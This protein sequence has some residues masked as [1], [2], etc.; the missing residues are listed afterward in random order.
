MASLIWQNIGFTLPCQTPLKN[1][2]WTSWYV[3]SLAT[4]LFIQ[5]LV[6]ANDYEIIQVSYYWPF[7]RGIH[8][9]Q[10]DSPHKGPA[11]WK[12]VLYHDIITN[13]GP[14]SSQKRSLPGLTLFTYNIHT[15]LSFQTF[16]L[17][18]IESSP[19]PPTGSPSSQ[20]WEHSTSWRI[21]IIIRGTSPSPRYTWSLTP[22]YGNVNL[23]WERT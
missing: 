1:I 4:P 21:R 19:A 11:M 22:H 10:V 16:S 20:R 7:V 12:M 9:S 6:Q 13:T 23:T 14:V 3:K 8:L 5:Q 15:L 18:W 17:I 2:T